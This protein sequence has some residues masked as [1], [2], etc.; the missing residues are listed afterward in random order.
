MNYKEKIKEINLSLKTLE[1]NIEKVKSGF[2]E[3]LKLDPLYHQIPNFDDFKIEE[4][5]KGVLPF[6][7]AVLRFNK[8]KIVVH[9]D[10]FEVLTSNS[11]MNFDFNFKIKGLSEYNLQD[12]R[13]LFL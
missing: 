13:K 10:F 6:F 9:D 7:K 3:K 11:L 8:I 5:N 2:T 12:L 4:T 1:K